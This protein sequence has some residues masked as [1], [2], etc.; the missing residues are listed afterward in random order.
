MDAVQIALI[1]V[2][3]LI[4]IAFFLLCYRSIVDESHFEAIQLSEVQ[5]NDDEEAIQQTLSLAEEAETR[6]DMFDDGDLSKNFRSLYHDDRVISLLK[7]KLKDH[8]FKIKAFFIKGDPKLKFI[9]AF[10]NNPQVDIYTLK[11]NNPRLKA[12]HY[13]IIDGGRK[14]IIATHNQ[15]A[16][17]RK[18]REIV[19]EGDSEKD[20]ASVGK[21]VLRRYEPS[22]RLFVKLRG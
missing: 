17:K 15:G 12:S 14:G 2:S 13:R 11:P 21:T 20:I 18:Y 19:V 9:S 3:L 8:S 1:G 16:D 6:I 10:K 4:G 22:K 7:D 5:E